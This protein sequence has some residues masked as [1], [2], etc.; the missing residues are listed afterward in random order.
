MRVIYL[1]YI[2]I[3]DIYIYVLLV[4][5]EAGLSKWML[6]YVVEWH[7]PDLMPAIVEARAQ[8]PGSGGGMSDA[9]AFLGVHLNTPIALNARI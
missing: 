5:E 7:C 2:Y 8:Q 1:Q 6:P 3:Y 4:F 9:P